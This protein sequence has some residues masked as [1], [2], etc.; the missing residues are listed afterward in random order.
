MPKQRFSLYNIY[1]VI[2]SKRRNRYIKKLKAEFCSCHDSVTFS[3]IK[4]VQGLKY[5]SIGRDTSFGADLY[6][7][8]WDSYQ[9][10]NIQ[11]TE[12]EK[13]EV[14]L[15]TQQLTPEIIIGNKCHFGAY[16]HIT[17]ANRII[18]G[19]GVLTGK[20]VTITDNS[21]GKTDIKSLR[22]PPTER[23]LFSK[24]PVRIGDNVWIGDK[25][26]ILPGVTIGQGSIIA[27]NA[28]VTH[29]VPEYCVIAGN[30][31]KIIKNLSKE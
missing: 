12:Q 6:L 21:H 4:S 5:I 28:V 29:D 25:A 26:T 18:V 31:A 10:I 27:A 19:D 11:E 8:A 3:S 14:L 17:C 13:G 20:W 7:T 24:G 22:I 30:P 15:C 1:T 2:L 16:N 9:Y 23:P